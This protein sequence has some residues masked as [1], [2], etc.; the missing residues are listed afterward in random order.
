MRR[1][2]LLLQCKTLATNGLKQDREI[3]KIIESDRD[4]LVTRV[5]KIKNILMFV[6]QVAER[7][8]IKK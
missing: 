1:F 5:S 6:D 4:L 7:R 3:E 8:K 2:H